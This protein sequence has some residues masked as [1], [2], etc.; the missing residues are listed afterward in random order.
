[1][2]DVNKSRHKRKHP[3]WPEKEMTDLWKQ[4]LRDLL[5]ENKRTDVKPRNWTELAAMLPGKIHKSSL[6]KMMKASKSQFVQ[7]VCDALNIPLPM[8]AT[9]PLDSLEDKV[10]K[11]SAEQRAAVE[12]LV[13]FHLRKSTPES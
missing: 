7:P 12:A 10:S 11:L 8:Q 4:G 5:A 6:N 1:M 13:D 9:K 2:P 3:E